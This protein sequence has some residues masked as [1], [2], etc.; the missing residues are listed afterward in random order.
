MGIRPGTTSL[1]DALQLLKAHEWVRQ[2]E[3]QIY[4]LDTRGLRGYGTIAWEWSAAHPPQ[5]DSAFPGQMNY[6]E[7]Y[8]GT[9]VESLSIHTLLRPVEV[10]AWI[11]SPDAARIHPFHD[12]E[13]SYLLTYS[14]SPDWNSIKT[15]L[16]CPVKLI[17]YWHSRA[18]ISIRPLQWPGDVAPMTDLARAC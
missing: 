15:T 2:V 5:I 1:E 7:T 12:A 14:A 4:E 9:V 6:T 8:G 18:E 16:P 17:D 3:M 11:G 10:E 13:V